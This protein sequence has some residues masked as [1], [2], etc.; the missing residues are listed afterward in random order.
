MNMRRPM[1]GAP[2]EVKA[3]KPARPEKPAA[4]EVTVSLKREGDDVL[5][6]RLD[7]LFAAVADIAV[8]Q[9]VQLQSIEALLQLQRKAMEKG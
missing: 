2:G 3:E 1:P 5:N 8:A 4:V 7:E 9:T 6:K